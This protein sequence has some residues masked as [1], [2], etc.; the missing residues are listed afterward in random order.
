M[1][2]KVTDWKRFHGTFKADPNRK[3]DKV[4]IVIEAS[5]AVSST[6]GINRVPIYITDIQFQTGEQ[7]TGWTPNTQE[8]MK[9]LTWDNDEWKN[10]PSPSEFKGS[11]PTVYKGI[12]RRWFNIVGRGHKAIIV[13][14]YL[15]E[16]WDVPI[17]P[18][19]LDI[20]LY[21]KD[22]YDLLRVSTNVGVWLPEEEQWYKQEGGIYQEIKEKY[23]DVINMNLDYA[24]P[25]DLK[26]RQQEISNWENIIK[27]IFDKHPLHR[28]YTR[29]F[30]VDGA[31]AGSEIKIHA[32]TRIATLNG[33]SIPIVGERYIDI[34][35]FPYPIDRK[36][37]LIA[38]K[39]VTAIRIEFYRQR[40]RTIRTYDMN[41][42]GEYELVEKR[43]KYMEDA[44][45]GYYG[46]VSFVQ[47][48]YGRSRV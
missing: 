32:T 46:T 43:F 7:L 48:T 5:D 11:P 21:P 9:K 15:P 26:R 27:P 29:E 31:E 14:N 2:I 25:M 41:S 24:S 18:T 37:F 47:W 44:G 20:T 10:V 4:E 12:T 38:P 1:A 30:W 42:S 40:E 8:M 17:L 3:V 19:G 39:G 23:E 16:N 6:N 13:P 45:I 28:R 36:K 22:D 33:K 34:H 35:G